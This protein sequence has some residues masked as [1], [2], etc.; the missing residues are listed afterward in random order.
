MVRVPNGAAHARP[1][2]PR[3]YSDPPTTG[4][5]YTWDGSHYDYTWST[6]GFTT[7]YFWRIGVRFDDGQTYYVSIGLR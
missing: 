3:V 7:G 2:S 6:N 4:T 5:T 1:R